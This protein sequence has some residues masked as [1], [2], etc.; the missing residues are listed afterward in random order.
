MFFNVCEHET[1]PQSD[2]KRGNKRLETALS[3]LNRMS[4]V[5]CK[6]CCFVLCCF[7]WPL[8][9]LSPSW[10]VSVDKKAEQCH[11]LDCAIHPSV[12]AQCIHDTTGTVLYMGW[13]MC[14]CSQTQLFLL[15][16][17]LVVIDDCSLL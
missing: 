13:Y 16:R 1:I 17:R 5:Y 8:I 9:V 10:T 6:L 7:R 14:I 4:L 11:V 3:P 15:Y 2:K 12:V